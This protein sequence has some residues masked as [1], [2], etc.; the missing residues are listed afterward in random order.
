MTTANQAYQKSVNTSLIMRAIREQPCIS[1]TEIADHTGLT[2][3]TVT[4]LARELLDQ[5]LLREVD[6]DPLQTTGGRPRIGLRINAE[7]LHIAGIDARPEG[8]HAVIVDLAGTVRARRS[9]MTG[10]TGASLREVLERATEDLASLRHESG[11]STALIGVGLS[12]PARVDPIH[13]TIVESQS[14][15]LRDVSIRSVTSLPASLP[16]LLEN[17]A[18]AV[19][20][21][22]L[23]GPEG[24]GVSTLLAVTARTVPVATHA[25]PEDQRGRRGTTVPLL[26]VGT[27]IVLNGTVYH[28]H[29][30]GAGEFHSALWTQ[31]SAGETS[32]RPWPPATSRDGS[33][34]N[35]VVD[36]LGELF[37]S[38]SSPASILR[39]QAIVYGG[40]LVDHQDAI[41]RLLQGDLA[42]RFIDPA[43]SR[44]P[45][46]PAWNGAFAGAV[47]AAMM[48]VE[49]LFAV[50]SLA[51]GR[52]EELPD[53]TTL[54]PG[55]VAW[56]A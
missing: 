54:R 15:D 9:N 41:Q 14:F 53:W 38:L 39:P 21:G 24:G 26:R 46:Q 49:R 44:I 35:E 30:F 20:W 6:G 18:N 34:A 33:A 48:F 29:D 31:G 36:A 8:Y 42:G 45:V 16:L 1:R 19:A 37:E 23:S 56:T 3:S 50:P 32:G 47:G 11:E 40:D 22:A 4:N 7:A 27:G 51:H 17:D 2:K 5:D 10:G 25:A 13:G 28:G 55:Q 52:P 43:V 12:V